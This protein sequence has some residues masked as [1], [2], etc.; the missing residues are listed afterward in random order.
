MDPSDTAPAL[1]FTLRIWGYSPLH[2]SAFNPSLNFAGF[3]LVLLRDPEKAGKP[4]RLFTG[5][6][7]GEVPCVVFNEA[8]SAEL[9][10]AVRAA[11]VKKR[12]PKARK[13]AA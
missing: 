4:S 3:D 9:L 6:E 10:K 12:G 5:A 1:V 11:L 2:R 8:T 13:E 7:D